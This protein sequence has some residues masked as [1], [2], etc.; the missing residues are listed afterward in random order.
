MRFLLGIFLGVGLTVGC[1]Y[2]YD[3]WNVRDNSATA[4]AVRPMVN[5]DVVDQNWQR[6]TTRMR[7]EWDKLAAK[8]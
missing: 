7:K 4:A 3:S 2:L 8:Q 5:W 6:A 1:A